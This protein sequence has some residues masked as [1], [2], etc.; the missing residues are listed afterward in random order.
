[1][2]GIPVYLTGLLFLPWLYTVPENR[3]DPLP[4]S[5]PEGLQF[6]LVRC[7]DVLLSIEQV[8]TDFLSVFWNVCS[9]GIRD[10]LNHLIVIRHKK[11]LLIV[12]CSQAVTDGVITVL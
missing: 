9:L 5:K 11:G 1:M 2:P 3:W 6:Y 12:S 10:N 7:L 4:F 8:F